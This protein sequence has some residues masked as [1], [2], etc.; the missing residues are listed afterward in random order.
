M[1]IP[2]F[3]LG[4]FLTLY[5]FRDPVRVIPNIDNVILSPADGKI[6]ELVEINNCD[7]LGINVIKIGIFMSFFD[8]HINRSPT[9]A[10]VEDILYKPGTFYKAST[11]LA[12]QENE[13]NTIVLYNAEKDLR[14]AIR[15]I[16]G[17]LARRIVCDLKIG[18]FVEK[19]Q[20]IGIIKLGSRTELYL[21]KD[22]VILDA[23][24]GYRVKAGETILGRI[25]NAI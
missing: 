23:K 18:N 16:A 10:R 3:I 24:L 9:S 20:K 6:I 14:L 12:V 17:I 19:G 21:P 8:V 22:K 4:F 13:N 1:L 2:L 11:N 15:Q 7:V 25:V 5:F